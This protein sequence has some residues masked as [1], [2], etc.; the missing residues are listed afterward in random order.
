MFCR[1]NAM[2]GTSPIP[3][4]QTIT[5]TVQEIASIWLYANNED[6]LPGTYDIFRR[7]GWGLPIRFD[8]RVDNFRL[9]DNS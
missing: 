4:T 2:I 1:P 5:R 8:F 3:S 9:L 7:T 6:D